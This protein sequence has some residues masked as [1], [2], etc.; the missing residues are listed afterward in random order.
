MEGD[1]ARQVW[2]R[3]DWLRGLR[4]PDLSD[5]VDIASELAALD[6]KIVADLS[7]LLDRQRDGMVRPWVIMQFIHELSKRRHPG[8]VLDPFVINPAACSTIM[9]ITSAALDSCR[10]RSGTWQ[11]PGPRRGLVARGSTPC[12]TSTMG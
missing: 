2:L 1:L 6:W 9:I 4:T 7:A 5:L 12:P 10:S 3:A 8:R 11:A